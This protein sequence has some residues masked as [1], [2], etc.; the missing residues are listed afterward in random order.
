MKLEKL[1]EELLEVVENAKPVPFSAAKV[2]IDEEEISSILDEMKKEVLALREHIVQLEHAAGP[3]RQQNALKEDI[4][5]PL[6]LD[7]LESAVV[8]KEEAGEMAMVVR[9]AEKL[10]ENIRRQ[11]YDNAAAVQVKTIERMNKLLIEIQ[12]LLKGH[13]DSLETERSILRDL[14]RRTMRNLDSTFED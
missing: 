1:F 3:S 11:A 10:S 14:K 12:D 2:M 4:I 8:P 13:V 5:T 7:E 9:E 6:M